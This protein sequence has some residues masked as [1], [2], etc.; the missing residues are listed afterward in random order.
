[1]TIARSEPRTDARVTFPDGCVYSAPVGTPLLT[2]VDA[3]F[4][5]GHP[6]R[7]VLGAVVD[8]QLVEL[9]YAV[10]RD[11]KIQPIFLNDSDGG[12]IYRRSLVFLL[13]TAAAELFPGVKI[14]VEH[15]IPTGGFY[16]E[17]V[18]RP[19]FSR[20][21]L[22]AILARMKE[23]V[24][25]DEPFE[26]KT[27][28]LAEAVTWFTDHGDDD[29]VRLLKN[30]E[31][32]Y[33]TIYTLRGKIDYLFGY[34]VPS[35]GYLSIF[36]LYPMEQGF[37]LVYPR[38][39]FTDSLL[40]YQASSKLERVFQQE[41]AWRRVMGLEDIGTLN[42]AIEDGRIREEVLIAE[43]LHSRY[44]G[45]IARMIAERHARGLKLVLIA[46]PSSAGKTTFSKRLAVQLMAYGIQPFTLE[47]D[48]YFVDRE[49]TPR[50]EHGNYDFESLDAMDRTRMNTD[51]QGLIAGEEV[52]MPHFDFK[53]GRSFPGQVAKLMPDQI[54]IAEGIHGLNPQLLPSIPADRV[55]RVYVSALTA[56]N[57]DRHN[58]VPTTDVRLLRR[59]LRDARTRGYKAIDTISRWESVRRGEKR[60]IF[61][62]QENADVMFNSSLPYELA[63]IRAQAEPLLRQV[64]PNTR[65]Y[66]EAKRLLSF[67][68]WVRPADSSFVPDDSI[69]REF[70]GGSILESY[71]PGKRRG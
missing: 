16:C 15:S 4:P 64:D 68:R 18:G 27:I 6:E 51:V 19:N 65:H 41:K 54:I 48:N 35:T 47:M 17:P 60:N 1:M 52:Q 22:D 32:D 12:R 10:S 36:A 3:A 37:I 21:E 57:L 38:P 55:F 11:I 24:A 20:A 26:R 58:R 44:L 25:A 71:I 2:Y 66:I 56:L 43:A 5:D 33:L 34:M 53:Q 39:E 7:P 30:R 63:M 14:A 8:N 28:P 9:T 70:I 69:L 31:K 13:I 61:P 42:H 23:I 67:L 46:G 29:M 40:P 62:H 50:D 59:I 49:H 45:E